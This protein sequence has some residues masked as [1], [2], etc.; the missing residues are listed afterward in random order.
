MEETKVKCP[1]CEGR[2][3]FGVII[4]GRPL[5]GCNTGFLACSLCKGTGEIPE[6]QLS[7][8]ARGEAMRNDRLSRD[9]SGREEAKR[10][11]ISAAELSD[12]EMGRVEPIDYDYER[13]KLRELAEGNA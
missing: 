6:S 10:L 3:S 7:W 9:M 2:K 13:R 12:M 4:C 5:G 1:D 11:G 8:V